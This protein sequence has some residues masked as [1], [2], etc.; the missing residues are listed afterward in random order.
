[1]GKMNFKD[2]IFVMEDVDAVS[3]VVRRRDGKTTA[4]TTYTEQVEMPINKSIWKML[5]E[6][7]DDNCQELVKLLIEKSERLKLASKN[8]SLMTSTARQMASIPGLTL[9]GENMDDEVTSKVAS[10]AVQNAQKVMSDNRTVDEFI[11]N[12]AKYLKR[13]I[14]AEV[15]IT[16]D[17]EN[18]LLG[19]TIGDSMSSGSFVSLMKPGLTRNVSYKK[20]YGDSNNIVVASEPV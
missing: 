8:P 6:S 5:L 19:I 18:E 15:E 3:K 11:G 4:E 20:P 1:M 12:H 13:M 7:H 2:I 16:E 17:F 9:V 10:E 14:D